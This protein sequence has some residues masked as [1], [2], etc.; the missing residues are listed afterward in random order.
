MKE[1]AAKKGPDSGGLLIAKLI[2]GME[3]A[4]QDYLKISGYPS[5]GHAPESF[6]QAGA[7]REI[8]GLPKTWLVL[9][10]N[11]RATVKAAGSKRLGAPR[12][13]IKRGRF[14]I[15]AY[16]DN[17]SPRAAVEVKA[18]VNV[19]SKQRFS[20]DFLRLS[21]AIKSHPETS[22]QFASF[23]FLTVRQ[24]KDMD[25][26]AA[27]QQIDELV[28]KLQAEAKRLVQKTL[29]VRVHSGLKTHPINGPDKT[30]AWRI[31]AINFSR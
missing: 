18:P 24:G 30:G 29:K 11:V 27:S 14:D 31:T 3:K 8:K 7:A 16:W 6:L 15:V 12:K 13:G 19:L 5:P 22:F 4:C 2:R 21:D 17:T 28:E 23:L 25:F 9:E 10:E 20:K 26:E 1:K